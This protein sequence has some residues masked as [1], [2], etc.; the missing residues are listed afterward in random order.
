MNSNVALT[1][2]GGC[3]PLLKYYLA[4]DT[5]L[6]TTSSGLQVYYEVKGKGENLF[7]LHG[8]G[9][10]SQGL[11]P[12][13][14]YFC[15]HFRVFSLDLPGFGRS[16]TPPEVWGS[17]Q[18]AQCIHNIWQQLEIKNCNIIAHSFGGRIAIILATQYPGIIKKLV[19]TGSAGLPPHR[20]LDYYIKVYTAKLSKKILSVAGST[21]K[22]LQE[23]VLRL[24][25]SSDYTSANPQMR[26]ILVKV[27]NE[28][29]SEL[30]PQI[31][32]P[33][34]LV[35]GEKDTATPL[36]MGKTMN[37]LISDSKLI[38]FPSTGHFAYLE[39]SADFCFAANDFLRNK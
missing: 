32:I 27:V 17:H 36:V 14:N 9:G 3:Y 1:M 34:L 20:G 4:K 23:T 26:A 7:L 33:T 12:L 16:N 13:L 21:G 29:L 31:K 6:I 8:W 18:Y 24:L 37:K 39:K 35:W 10:S 25:G 2:Q 15:Q 28:D 11:R 5:M 19:L 30:L 22:K 38:V